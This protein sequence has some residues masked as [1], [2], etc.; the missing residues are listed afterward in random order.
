MVVYLWS[1]TAAASQEGLTGKFGPSHTFRF[2]ERMPLAECDEEI[3]CPQRFR[4]AIASRRHTDDKGYVK[5]RLANLSN[6]V[7]RSP[8]RDLQIDRRMKFTKLTQ[9]FGKKASRD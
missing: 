5:L 2:G 8:F 6:G 1:R 7:S 9:Q 3:L 4:M